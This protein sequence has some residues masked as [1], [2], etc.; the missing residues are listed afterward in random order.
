MRR[1]IASF[2]FVLALRATAGAPNLPTGFDTT[3]VGEH[4]QENG[5]TTDIYQFLRNESAEQTL[6]EIRAHWQAHS[7]EPTFESH[8]GE[9]LVLSQQRGEYWLTVRITHAAFGRSVGLYSSAHMFAQ[10]A[11]AKPQPP[12]ELPAGTQMARHTHS[13][14][15]EVGSDTWLLTNHDSIA[16]NAS[17]LEARMKVL[18]AE[19]D[20]SVRYPGSPDK[21]WAGEFRSKTDQWMMTV[22]RDDTATYVV[23]NRVQKEQK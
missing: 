14:D 4:L 16:T 13:R 12:F 8:I 22:H 20:A 19:R 23:I 21:A 11:R 3:V 7:A 5:I 2:L 15:L 6:A 9:D 18:G 17:M 1:L 10:G